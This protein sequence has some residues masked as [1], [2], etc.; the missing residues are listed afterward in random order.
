[1]LS[2][3]RLS[4]RAR[5]DDSAAALARARGH[6]AAGDEA[7]EQWL[8]EYEIGTALLVCLELTIAYS[9]GEVQAVRSSSDGLFIQ[10]DIH[11]SKVEQQIAELAADDFSALAAQLAARGHPI[12]AFD[13]DE[14]HVHVELDDELR[15][16]LHPP[17][18]PTASA[19]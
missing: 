12:D 7:W 6:A 10:S 13:L 18:G 1:M 5:P 19:G 9:D 3:Q 17:E 15:R 2:V 16:R 8:S 4:V 14:M 11:P